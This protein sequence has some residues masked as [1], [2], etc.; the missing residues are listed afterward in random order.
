[1]FRYACR[2]VTSIARCAAV[3]C[4][5]CVITGSA[6]LCEEPSVQPDAVSSELKAALERGRVELNASAD[7]ERELVDLNSKIADEK[8]NARREALSNDREALQLQQRQ[9]MLAAI[10][11][12]EP[13]IAA[14]TSEDGSAKRPEDNAALDNARYLLCYSFYIAEE[15][16]N[17]A[18]LGEWVARNRP[19]AE[20]AHNVGKIAMAAYV[21]LY[22]RADDRPKAMERVVRLGTFLWESRKDDNAAATV[23]DALTFWPNRVQRRLTSQE[24]K[25]LNNVAAA[26]R[27]KPLEHRFRVGD[28]AFRAWLAEAAFSEPIDAKCEEELRDETSEQLTVL[29]DLASELLE[30]A[31]EELAK[32][33]GN[34]FRRRFLKESDVAG[35]LALSHMRLMQGDTDGPQALL[36]QRVYGPLTLLEAD[37]KL[38]REAYFSTLE[39]DIL[40]HAVKLYRSANRHEEAVPLQK[41]L[42]Y[43]IKHG[44]RPLAVKAARE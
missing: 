26:S 42:D 20:V 36:E 2:H 3:L 24:L 38:I 13:A 11:I 33:M 14:F 37:H 21:Q 18:T 1:M 40:E 6:G 43:I 44:P 9:R 34:I 27:E 15:F 32:N 16:E 5:A 8:D 29:R 10:N 31:H 22:N 28:R 35:V 7:V 4:A 12:F 17:C 25:L 30:S 39:K 23:F 19:S 41:K